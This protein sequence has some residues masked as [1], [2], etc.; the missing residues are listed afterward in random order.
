MM[1]VLLSLVRAVHPRLLAV[2]A[3]ALLLVVAGCAERGTKIPPGTNQP[4]QFL[5]ER[6][7]KA[8]QEKRWFTAREFFQTLIDTYPQSPHRADAKLGLADAYLGD[9][10]AASQVLAINEYREFLS[11]FPTSP[12][13]DY[14]QYKLAMSHFSQMAKAGRDQTETNEALKEF[15]VLFEK[16]PNSSLLPE[17]RLKQREAKDRLGRSEYLVGLTYFRLKWYP[18][19]VARLQ[20][21]LKADPQYT[22]RDA[23]YYYLA[24]ALT[25]LKRQAE[26]LPL[27][28]KIPQEFERSEY[29][30]KAKKRAAELK[31]ALAT[32]P[33]APAPP[34]PPKS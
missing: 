12:R 7:T 25:E 21:L 33:P 3:L 1:L 16:Y 18:G 34:A 24:E 17:A 8:L 28:E 23:V 11:F 30:E 26:A 14:A 20:A 4:D 9:G 15:E 10:S 32:Q 27:Y 6:G 19:A 13:A 29:I 31:T 22:E 5:F 2:P